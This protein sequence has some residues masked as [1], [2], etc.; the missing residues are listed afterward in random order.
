MEGHGGDVAVC[1]LY[2]E[3]VT[4]CFSDP[5][6]LLYRFT[7]AV[8]LSPKGL[9]RG[10]LGVSLSAPCFISPLLASEVSQSGKGCVCRWCAV[11]DS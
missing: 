8:N 5:F 1:D 3:D 4:R 6:A 10:A 11:Q 7:L 9:G 2:T